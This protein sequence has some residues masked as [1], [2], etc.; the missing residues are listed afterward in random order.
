LLPVNVNRRLIAIYFSDSTVANADSSAH[1][2]REVP[3]FAHLAKTR[4]ESPEL[5]SIKKNFLRFF[6]KTLQET[7]FP[8]VPRRSCLGAI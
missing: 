7:L 4:Q 8:N 5:G 6:L 3:D 2:L 1:R